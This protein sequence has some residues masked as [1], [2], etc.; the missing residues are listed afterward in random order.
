MIANQA[1][2]MSRIRV[3]QG[4]ELFV[5]AGDKRRTGVHSAAD[6]DQPAI[7]AQAKVG[8]GIGFIDVWFGKELQPRGAKYLLRVVENVS[9]VFPASG[10]IKQADQ[11]S[12]RAGANGIVE[13]SCDSLPSEHC[14]N[15]GATDLR[16]D[17]RSR[18]NRY[19]SRLGI[20][21]S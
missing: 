6:V 18:L 12:L 16:E 17:R 21:E 2:G 19:R 3:A 10:D 20:T 15:V 9:V 7:E 14:S 4:A 11:N 13:I 5:V 1:R 8:H